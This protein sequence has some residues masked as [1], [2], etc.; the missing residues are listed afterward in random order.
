MVTLCVT[1]LSSL[2]HLT[3][4]GSAER[5]ERI[6]VVQ[7]ALGDASFMSLH[8]MEAPEAR[9]EM[10][11]RAHLPDYVDE[12]IR[13]APIEKF[14]RLDGT[15][16]MSPGTLEA[17][18]RAAGAAVLCVDEV[19]SG[20]VQNAFAA[21]RPP[22]H[23][24][25]YS[26][27]GGGCIFNNAAIAA[28]HAQ[29]VHGARKVA[30]VDFDVHHGDGT[31][32]IFWSDPD[33]MVC[34]THERPLYPGTGGP[35]ERGSH[36]QIVNVALRAGDSGE[37]FH[38]AYADIILPRIAAFGPDLIVLSAGFDAHHRDRLSHIELHEDDFG[39]VT[40]ALMT[41]ARS[42]CDGR[43]VSI[44]EGGYDLAGLSLSVRAHVRRL[45]GE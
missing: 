6:A 20:R 4:T 17:A 44:L 43:I 35:A 45:M 26:K 38:A 41:L 12:I 10:L 25:H 14:H 39:K 27:S 28:R 7:E 31:Q 36:N 24:A 9:F 29:A 34:S 40:A 37:A 23:H 19:M 30:I 16:V 42:V 1:H 3:G 21:M 5:P 22:G 13:V 15:T 33:V 8:R 2:Q 11:S 18:R 32:D